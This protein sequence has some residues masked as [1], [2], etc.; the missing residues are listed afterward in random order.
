VADKIL[1]YQNRN[2]NINIIEQLEKENKKNKKP[3]INPFFQFSTI[4]EN[5]DLYFNVPY[6]MIIKEENNEIII[7]YKKLTYNVNKGMYVKV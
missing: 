3:Y 7:Y 6:D 1:Y 5:S 2:K 4:K